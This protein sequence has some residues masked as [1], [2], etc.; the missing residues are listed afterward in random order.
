MKCLAR[1]AVHAS[2]D[3]LQVLSWPL[4]QIDPLGQ[5]P[6]ERP[7]VVLV[8]PSVPDRAR[9]TEVDWNSSGDADLSVKSLLL[10]LISGDLLSLMTLEPIGARLSWI[11]EDP[12]T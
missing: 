4:Q 8:Q 2:L 7:V 12:N 6:A 11:W 3:A 5:I 10:A 9:I 1:P